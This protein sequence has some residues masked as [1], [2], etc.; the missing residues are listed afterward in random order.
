MKNDKHCNLAEVLKVLGNP[1][2]L[3]II[4]LLIDQDTCVN[5]IGDSL[6]IRQSTVSQ[7]L[8]LLKLKGIVGDKRRGSRVSYFL[9]DKRIGEIIKLFD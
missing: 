3:K 5:S 1:T 9:K 7:H 6:A 4:E 2:R 8:A